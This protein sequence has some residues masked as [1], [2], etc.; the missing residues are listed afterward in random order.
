MAGGSGSCWCLQLRPRLPQ[1]MRTYTHACIPTY[2]CLCVCA[3]TLSLSLSLFLS[4]SHT[5]HLATEE[6]DHL[7]RLPTTRRSK[8]LCAC[9]CA[10]RTC[11]GG[12][13]SV[14]ARACA[15]ARKRECVCV[16]GGIS[17]RARAWT[18][19]PP[20]HRNSRGVAVAGYGSCT[21]APPPI[22]PASMHPCTR[23]LLALLG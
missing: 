8:H 16:C 15:C 18:G 9:V 2:M 6:A 13:L 23:A 11:G 19:A 7:G 12:I 5:A 3:R 22:S 20:P 1:I 4:F 21:P 14:C 17:V 10:R